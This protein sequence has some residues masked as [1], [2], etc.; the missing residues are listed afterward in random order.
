MYRKPVSLVMLAL[1]VLFVIAPSVMAAEEKADGGPAVPSWLTDL[2]FSGDL[3]IRYEGKWYDENTADEQHGRFRMR[4]GFEKKLTDELSAAFRLAS[5]SSD[6]ATSTNQ[7][8]TGQ[9]SEKTVWIDLAYVTYKPTGIKGLTIGA[10]KLKNPF[11]NTDLVWDSDV[12][13]EGA[14]A[15]MSFSGLDNFTPFVTAAGLLNYENTTAGRDDASTAAL[16]G[17]FDWKVSDNVSWQSAVAYYNYLNYTEAGNWN[18]SNGNTNAGGVLTAGDFNLVNLTNIV[19][20]DIS[21]LPVEI[22]FDYVKNTG[23]NAPA[24][25]NGQDT[26]YAA[27]FKVGSSK[28]PGRWDAGY[29]YAKI[30]ANAVPGAFNDSDFGYANRKG[31]K[32]SVNYCIAKNVSAGLA[33]FRTEPDTGGT[34]KQTLVQA[35][36]VVKF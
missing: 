31:H 25:D 16:Q 2:K 21:E 20:F 3:R 22:F 5:G 23:E 4:F 35:D 36:I 10:G 14:Y 29:K 30:E 6:D 7:T 24:P 26:G 28:N 17:G 9:Y 11:V 18:K 27:G 33:V 8:L 1:A 32:V 13:P 34:E 15:T 19:T 12:N